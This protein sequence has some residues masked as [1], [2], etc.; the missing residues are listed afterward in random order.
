MRLD[1]NCDDFDSVQLYFR[2]RALQ[3]LKD[4]IFL[5]EIRERYWGASAIFSKEN[6]ERLHSIY[7]YASQR[8]KGNYEHAREQICIE[9]KA[10]I[11]LITS[12]DCEL[13]QYLLYKGFPYEIYCVK[14][15][16]YDMVS[17]FY[18]DRKASR[19]GVEYMNHI[20]EGIAVI[21]WVRE[22]EPYR[23]IDVETAKAAFSVHPIFQMDDDLKYTVE[24]GLFQ[25][26]SPKVIV[27]AMEYRSVA[28]EYLSKRHLESL[29]EIRL[30]PLPE[31]NL[32]LLADKIQNLKDFRR[33][34]YGT[35]P[36]S[37]ELDEYFRN[38]LKRLGFSFEE[39]EKMSAKLYVTP[40]IISL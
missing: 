15:K 4:S 32:M 1:K 40:Q 13:E 5:E 27:F 10:D 22:K 36:R 20:D 25:S 30:S 31:V 9:E 33:Y 26:M 28:N 3:L 17:K 18:G 12:D 6:G 23:N 7:L 34:H 29:E 39:Y 14:E 24:K 21:E 16:H 37:N 38:W 19:S 11:V 2:Q 8:G 35:H